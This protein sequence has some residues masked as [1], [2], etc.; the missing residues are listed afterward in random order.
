MW[1]ACENNRSLVPKKFLTMVSINLR[2]VNWT[3]LTAIAFARL[4][5]SFFLLLLFFNTK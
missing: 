1:I 3:R 4:C 2:F 5:N